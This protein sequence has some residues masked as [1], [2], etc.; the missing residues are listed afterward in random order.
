LTA[1]SADDAGFLA[2]LE[3]QVIENPYLRPRERYR[4]LQEQLTEQLKVQSANKGTIANEKASKS[5]AIANELS[6]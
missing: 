1:F 2:K 6:H 5:G 3:Q 4:T